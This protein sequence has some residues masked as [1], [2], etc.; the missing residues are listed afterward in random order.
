MLAL[1]VTGESWSRRCPAGCFWF[2]EVAVDGGSGDTEF[3]GDL[4]DGVGAFSVCP[5]FLVHFAGH[6][7]FYVSCERAFDPTLIGR[8]VI[9]L[10][11]NYGCAVARSDE[12]KALGLEMGAPWFKL[13]TDATLRGAGL[14]AKS[15][16]YEL[17]GDLSSRVMQL[18][19]RHSAGVEVYFLYPKICCCL[20]RWPKHWVRCSSWSSPDQEDTRAASSVCCRMRLQSRFQLDREPE[21]CHDFGERR[22]RNSAACLHPGDGWPGH[23]GILTESHLRPA[24]STPSIANVFTEAH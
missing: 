10:S 2:G 22:R 19:G 7:S 6:N 20:A 1:V 18:L 16:K 4:F 8:P 14:V 17:Y 5:L 15:S 23:S 11:N 13:E 24:F 9:V 3:R 21:C 12:A